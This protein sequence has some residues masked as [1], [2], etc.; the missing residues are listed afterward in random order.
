MA[1]VAVVVAVNVN[2]EVSRKL[3]YNHNHGMVNYNHN[4]GM[5]FSL[6]NTIVAFPCLLFPFSHSLPKKLSQ[7]VK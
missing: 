1:V 4:H 6:P 5:D 3:N 7:Y 2:V